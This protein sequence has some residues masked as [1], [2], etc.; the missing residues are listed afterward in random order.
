MATAIGV[1]VVAW[2]GTAGSAERTRWATGT[3][4]QQ[5]LGQQFDILWSGN[6]LRQALGR[7]SRSTRVAILIDRRVDPGQKVD[8]KLD[9]VRLEA[10]LAKIAD[11]CG[12]G[13]SRLGP[14]VYV[15]PAAAAKRLRA[16][17]AALE[18]EVRTLPTAERQKFFR[19]DS[20]VWDDLATPRELLT[21]LARQGGIEIGG[22]ERVPHDLW[23]AADLPPLSL[24][25]R[26]TLIATQFDLSLTVTAEGRGVKLV[27][28]AENLSR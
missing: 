1:W 20:L 12:L 4:F 3:A 21:E 18:K 13:V 14:V 17:A 15:G 19:Q 22:L 26:L 7:L 9:G 28:A 25:D 16:V 11:Q 27:P 24:V 2:A 6:P 8:L 23:A 5:A 10:A